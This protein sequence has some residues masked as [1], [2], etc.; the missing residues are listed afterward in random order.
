MR[1]EAQQGRIIFHYN[2]IYEA[3]MNHPK[4]L[5]SVGL[6]FVT[7]SACANNGT[8]T[9]TQE[10]YNDT[11]AEAKKSLKTASKA[12]YEWRDSGKILKKADKAAK[13]GNLFAATKLAKQVKNQGELALAQSKDQANAGPR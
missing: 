12:N 1:T 5:V 4:L 2:T 10:D 8:V 3:N 7:L 9:A 11:V 13:A 6:A